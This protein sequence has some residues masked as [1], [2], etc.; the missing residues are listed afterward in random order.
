M[1]AESKYLKYAGNVTLMDGVKTSNTQVWLLFPSQNKQWLFSKN[2]LSNKYVKSLDI[3]AE[4]IPLQ[5]WTGP[6]DSRSWGS[7]NFYKIHTWRWKI[8][9]PYAPAA[10]TPKDALCCSFMVQGEST[11]RII[12][13]PEGLDQWNNQRSYR[14]SN[15]QPSS[16]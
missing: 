13:R 11:P 10:F 9:Y 6:W 7:M 3:E 14:E 8:C 12:G 4:T 15:P 5:F 2:P 16:L 1:R